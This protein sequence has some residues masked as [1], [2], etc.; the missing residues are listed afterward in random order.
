M[1]SKEPFSL[2]WCATADDEGK[3]LRDF[4]GTAG[5]SRRALTAIKF[6]GGKIQVN[7]TEVTVRYKLYD[8]DEVKVIF[9]REISSEGLKAEQ[10]PLQIVYEDAYIIVL[11]K[12]ANMNTIPSRDRPDGS[13]ANALAGYYQKHGIPSTIHV[14]TRLDRDTSGLVLIAKHSHVHHLLSE[15]QKTGT[16]KRCYQAVVE[17]KITNS[18][19]KIEAPIGRKPS[20]IIEREVRA[21]GQYACTLFEVIARLNG[22]THVELNLLTGRTHQIRVH[23]AYY[24]HPLAGDD[25]YGGQLK[26]INRQALHCVRLE[27][28]HPFKK[29]TLVFESTIPEDIRMLIN[30]H[31]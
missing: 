17:G 20:S 2:S 8:G 18:C 7:N 3:L 23:M 31:R 4:L 1:V 30:G 29:Q 15:Q 22:F 26:G 12:P 24:G 25:L 6:G 5:I 10:I 16:V 19:G 9:P 21:D 11:E 14:V 28:F 13:L 27:F